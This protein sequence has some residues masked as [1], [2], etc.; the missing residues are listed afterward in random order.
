MLKRDSKKIVREVIDELSFTGLISDL[1]TVL[2]LEYQGKKV[3][4]F[5]IP[6]LSLLYHGQIIV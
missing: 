6:V 4:I 2:N 3:I 1:E 5:V